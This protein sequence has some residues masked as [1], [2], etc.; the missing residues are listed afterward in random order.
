MLKGEDSEQELTKIITQLS[1]IEDTIDDLNKEINKV[2]EST[3]KVDKRIFE[4]KQDSHVPL[5]QRPLYITYGCG[6]S[7]LDWAPVGSYGTIYKL[8]YSFSGDGIPTIK[9]ILNPSK[10]H[11]NLI[12]GFKFDLFGPNYSKGLVTEGYSD[13]LF[14]KEATE[15][16]LK[17]LD[18]LTGGEYTAV[19]DGFSNFRKPSLHLAIKNAVERFLKNGTSYDNVLIL[20][21]D[22]DKVLYS[23]LEKSIKSA[24]PSVSSSTGWT[25]KEIIYMRAFEEVL[26]SLG[27]QLVETLEDGNTGIVGSAALLNL[28]ECAFPE[29]APNWFKDRHFFAKMEC[30]Y[31]TQTFLEKLNSLAAAIEDKNA[32]QTVNMMTSIE[33]ETD[34]ELLQIMEKHGLIADAGV[35]CLLWGSKTLIDNFLNAGAMTKQ[36]DK[37]E[38]EVAGGITI[39]FDPETIDDIVLTELDNSIHPIDIA[40]GI[41]LSYMKEVVDII[42]PPASTTPF[43]PRN[44][45]NLDDLAIPG[46]PNTKG[47]DYRKLKERYPLLSSRMPIFSFGT[48]NPNMTSVDF[49]I[50]PQYTARALDVR[51][52]I[53]PSQVKVDG[54]IPDS[55]K[56]KAKQMFTAIK[57]F[58]TLSTDEFGIPEG[59]KK[60]VDPFY[61]DPLGPLVNFSEWDS[62]FNEVLPQ[63]SGASVRKYRGE[64]PKQDY[65]SYMWG[66]FSKLYLTLDITPTSK[67]N[68]SHPFAEQKIVSNSV[69]LARRQREMFMIGHVH[70]TP[71]FHLCTQKRAINRPCLLYCV[72]PKLY[73]NESNPGKATTWYSGVYYIHGFRHK[74]STEGVES[75]FIITKSEVGN[76]A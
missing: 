65:Y 53:T 11:P 6:E 35:P 10:V 72:V 59:F 75:R 63:Y 24:T 1:T 61:L 41:N 51:N 68:I 21:P 36:I 33:P 60:M 42:Y 50:N 74:I 46:D 30:D 45:G 16:Q 2:S 5:V 55:F 7:L 23:H 40:L 19:I 27:L 3:K 38:T 52:T 71:M 4:E 32:S 73:D 28:E 14:N 31:I 18:K 58:D 9:L 17:S 56:S 20:L 54:I 76:N 44:T 34:F 43:G 49:D 22:L 48:K 12:G 13:Q 66:A 29:D 57:G 69:D 25:P 15:A 8:E 70:T 37:K 62:I 47:S 26:T 64:N 67:R 39:G